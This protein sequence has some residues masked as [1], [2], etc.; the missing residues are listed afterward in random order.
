MDGKYETII[1]GGGVVGN[2]IAYH[3]S[4]RYK[5][6]VLVLD[7]KYPLSGTSGSTQAWVW[8][9]N[10]TPS[11]YAELNYY[12]AELYPYLSKKIGD[13][14]Y[15]RTGGLSPFFQE[16]DK[17]KALY[18]AESYEKI[19]IKIKVLSKEEVLVKE[20]CINPKVVGAT[21]SSIDGNVN[22]FRLIDRYMRSAKKNNVEYSTYNKVTDIKKQDGQYI[23][24]SDKKN[25]MC[26]N[27]ILAGGTWSNELGN[28]LGIN[29]PIYQLRGQILVSEPLKPFLRHTVSG[30]RQAN[31]GEVLM[32]YSMEKKGF[33]RSTT[34]DVIQETANMAVHYVPSLRKAK[35]VRAFSGIR[36]MPED[37]F[38]IL[39]TVPGF[40]NLYVAAT[41]S[42]V[43]LSPLIGTLITEL[44]LDGETSF[45]IDNYSISRFN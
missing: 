35:I 40:E 3:L 19:G 14:E 37:G 28:M 1:I 44:I 5:E 4:E 9:H 23:I 42:G 10:K 41:H 30:L 31:N 34:L 24:V 2:G 8:V 16:K 26:K 7:K 17:E 29:I 6:G 32:G 13:V 22:P 15:K 12:S 43:T 20:Q 27:L 38:P 45:P 11:W 25:Y 33:N 18:L 21:Y 39:G 36:A